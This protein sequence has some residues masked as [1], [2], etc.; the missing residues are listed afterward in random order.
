MVAFEAA[1]FRRVVTRV[2]AFTAHLDL[3]ARDED[4]RRL[5]AG[6]RLGAGCA[7]QHLVGAR[8]LSAAASEW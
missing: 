3:D 1:R 5:L 6:C 8:I 4:V 7:R 2:I